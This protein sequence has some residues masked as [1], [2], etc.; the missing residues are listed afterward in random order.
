MTM[1]VGFQGGL[2]RSHSNHVVSSFQ[3]P[4]SETLTASLGSSTHEQLHHPIPTT[5]TS[6]TPSDEQWRRRGG[7]HHDSI[8]S[9][10][11]AFP[12]LKTTGRE[13]NEM[14]GIG[15]LPEF[16]N[17]GH[18]SVLVEP[19][20]TSTELTHN[21]FFQESKVEKHV[22]VQELI[23]NPL[24]QEPVNSEWELEQNDIYKCGNSNLSSQKECL[25]GGLSGSQGDVKTTVSDDTDHTRLTKDYDENQV[26]MV[27]GDNSYSHGSGGDDS[28]DLVDGHV[29]L[30]EEYL[31]AGFDQTGE[32]SLD[33]ISSNRVRCSPLVGSKELHNRRVLAETKEHNFLPP[34]SSSS[35][36]THSSIMFMASGFSRL[37]PD[38]VSMMTYTLPKCIQGAHKIR[39]KQ[40]LDLNDVREAHM[41]SDRSTIEWNEGARGHKA[42]VNEDKGHSIKDNKGNS[43]STKDNG[44]KGSNSQSDSIRG[45]STQ[46]TY[47]HDR[48]P[49]SSINASSTSILIDNE[50][51]GDGDR[52]KYSSAIHIEQA[53]SQRQ[54]SSVQLSS[55][56]Q[57]IDDQVELS[58]LAMS[59]SSRPHSQFTGIPRSQASNHFKRHDPSSM[60]HGSLPSWTTS[61]GSPPPLACPQ[62]TNNY[63]DRPSSIMAPSARL[64]M[65]PQVSVFQHPPGYLLK[66]VG[67]STPHVVGKGEEEGER[68]S[69]STLVTEGSG[70]ST[71]HTHQ[72]MG[73]T[74]RDTQFLEDF[75]DGF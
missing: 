51:A 37:S 8:S 57:V 20:Q 24:E 68:M 3:H 42:K 65:P 22:L 33:L 46:D 7:P 73:N 58:N 12:S 23:S 29:Q 18:S 30:S 28:A 19:P 69:A 75:I 2:F 47:L 55:V 61:P 53:A 31:V 16:E 39:D 6:S 60:V 70:S 17:G 64:I 49:S 52:S 48:L 41:I 66:H 27:H 44:G 1:E 10:T 67:V 32:S 26:E 72:G 62:A 45:Q 38:N 15:G 25:K 4:S 63:K 71:G 74:G 34:P 35:T 11:D 14:S 5:P 50:V 21:T 40:T 9:R 13:K 36:G 43:H 54:Q 56:S 59:S